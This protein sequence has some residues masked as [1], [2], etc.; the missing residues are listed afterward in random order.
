MP[1]SSRSST[2]DDVTAVA[3][4]ECDTCRV[5]LSIVVLEALDSGSRAD[6]VLAALQIRL[7]PAER[8]TFSAR[9]AARLPCN[10]LPDEARADIEH[11]LDAIDARWREYIMI[12]E[13][14]SRPPGRFTRSQPSA[15][16]LTG[17]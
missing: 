17:R 2:F 13:T 9:D 4:G 11:R 14:R 15:R 7:V 3:F 16:R 12:R 5:P 1:R 10:L 6:S 8:Q